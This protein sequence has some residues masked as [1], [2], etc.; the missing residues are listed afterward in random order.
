LPAQAVLELVGA[1]VRSAGSGAAHCLAL[2][3]GRA[4]APQ[5]RPG[6]PEPVRCLT[7]TLDARDRST[8]GHSERGARLAMPIAQLGLL[9][10]TRTDPSLGGLLPQGHPPEQ[11][12]AT[13][14]GGPALSGTPG[15]SPR[16]PPAAPTCSA[17]GSAAWGTRWSARWNTHSRSPTPWSPPPA[18][19]EYF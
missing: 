13:L 12:A 2:R 4:G 3:A 19:S 15:S 6:P 17:S 8:C 16:S 5:Y 1:T 18:R 9:P 7:A 14:A 10:Q 11:V